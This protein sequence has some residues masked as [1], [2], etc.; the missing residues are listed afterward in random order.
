LSIPTLLSFLRA[1]A[2]FKF[3]LFSNTFLSASVRS[4][5]L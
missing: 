5:I 4:A 3:L 1:F 2:P